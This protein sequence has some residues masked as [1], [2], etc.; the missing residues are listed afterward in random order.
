MLTRTDRLAIILSLLAVLASA[1]V[2]SA[3]FENIPHLED[4]IAYVWQAD[5]IAGG[6]LFLPSPDCPECFLVPFVIDHQG[7]RFG[8]YPPG[9]PA[10]LAI[11]EWLDFRSWINP[12]LAGLSAWLIY[13]LG[14]RLFGE[15]AAIFSLLLLITSPFFL[16]N[17]GSLLSHVWGLFLTVSFILGWL[18][19]FSDQPATPRWLTIGVAA[20]SLGVL[21]LT[22]P[23][24][25]VAVAI[26]FLIPG[27][28]IMFLGPREKRIRLVHLAVVAA[29]I[30]SLYFLWQ[31]AVTGDPLLNPYTLW[32]PYDRIGF[33]PG[34][35][36]MPE[37]HTPYYA[38]LNLK[39]N[40]RAAAG[41]MLGW[42]PY[43][44]VLLPFGI[45]A[46]S[47][48]RTSWPVIAIFPSLVICYLFY[49]IGAWLFGPRYY[50]E[51]L[52]A[53]VYL[54]AAGMMWLAG[55]W[56][57]TG[58]R[59]FSHW[60][61]RITYLIFAGLVIFANLYTYLPPRLNQMK[62]LYHASGERMAPF[63]SKEALALTPAVVIVHP[64]DDW[65]E[66]GAL[67]DL[68]NPYFNT[69]FVFTRSRGI[70]KDLTATDQFPDRQIFHYYPDDPF[71][72]YTAPRP[73][74]TPLLPGLEQSTPAQ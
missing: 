52:F 14:K 34:I 72:L 13:R 27:L 51:G 59:P 65:M 7:I 28:K 26:P 55:D 54:S 43:S 74:S 47:K 56:L 70:E 50:F 58:K 57:T 48:M 44:W 37:G 9:W 19:S 6:N 60:R 16:L 71:T 42:G 11:S 18:E 53:W 33:G 30:A 64:I 22:R 24:T 25:A 67:L 21:A 17:T 39:V 66:Y 61:S 73:A 62:G 32:W 35:G 38:W 36:V 68:S 10:L 45:I 15:T 5:A 20:L 49:W 41:D 63:Q 8:K 40:L 31:Y 69:A 23:L 4:E 29:A 46:L 12:L 2:G 1:W 3:I